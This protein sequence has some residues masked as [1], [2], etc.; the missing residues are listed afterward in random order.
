[1]NVSWGWSVY[2]LGM[3]TDGNVAGMGMTEPLIH[4]HLPIL[5]ARYFSGFLFLL[6]ILIACR[7]RSCRSEIALLSSSVSDSSDWT[8]TFPQTYSSR[9]IGEH[10]FVCR[11]IPWEVLQQYYLLIHIWM[12]VLSLQEPRHRTLHTTQH[13]I[14]LDNTVRHALDCS[15][16]M[17]KLLYLLWAERTRQ[18]SSWYLSIT[19]GRNTS[20]SSHPF[21]PYVTQGL[22]STL[23]NWWTVTFYR[24]A[25]DC[26]FVTTVTCIG[27]IDGCAVHGVAIALHS[28]ENWRE[29]QL[30]RV[31]GTW[32]NWCMGVAYQ[33]YGRPLL[34]K[35]LMWSQSLMTSWQLPKVSLVEPAYF[36]RLLRSS[37]QSHDK[38][39][40]IGLLRE[41]WKRSWADLKTPSYHIPATRHRRLK[42]CTPTAY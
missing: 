35:W 15:S 32:R 42:I 29:S 38:I 11:V 10:S 4:Q 21:E 9:H 19:C 24:I 25:A 37:V 13:S 41:D 22:V 28:A 31:C 34:R 23:R 39:H 16:F 2:I 33:R 14:H 3:L 7:G 1:M 27:V 12:T 20:I 40:F 8:G 18:N 5:C 17:F 6:H 36:S 30:W 26:T